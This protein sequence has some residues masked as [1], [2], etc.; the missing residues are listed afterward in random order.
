[1]KPLTAMK[2]VLE[3]NLNSLWQSCVNQQPLRPVRLT[4]GRG[5]LMRNKV[6]IKQETI[7]ESF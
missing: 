5:G 1:M 4:G 3:T 6:R 7:P 2:K